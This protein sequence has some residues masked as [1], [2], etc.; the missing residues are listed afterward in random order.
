[1]CVLSPLLQ[2]YRNSIDTFDEKKKCF[3]RNDSLLIIYL[4]SFFRVRHKTKVYHPGL[5]VRPV[6]TRGVRGRDGRRRCSR[7]SRVVGITRSPENRCG[8]SVKRIGD[9]AAAAAAWR[10][11]AGT[12]GVYDSLCNL[13]RDAM[14]HTNARTHSWRR[15][16]SCT[17]HKTLRIS[18][19]CTYYFF[20]IFPGD[21]PRT[22]SPITAVAAALR[23]PSKKPTR[24][25]RFA[26][27]RCTRW[28]TLRKSDDSRFRAAALV[29]R[30]VDRV[31]VGI[32]FFHSEMR[33][34]PF[35]PSYD[36][37]FS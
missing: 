32:F 27:R 9:C 34:K 29:F 3:F 11:F 6:G 5:T 31:S 13:G 37:L 2:V 4:T 35:S 18:P 12:D 17:R 15:N 8:A 20:N 22:F 36:F 19:F 7:C 30:D 14:V 28:W 25:A 10:P 23:A 33:K 16:A 24:C 26:L 1:M 21:S